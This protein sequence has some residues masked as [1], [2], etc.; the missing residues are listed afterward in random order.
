MGH[1]EKIDAQDGKVICSRAKNNKARNR[2]EVNFEM[3]LLIPS[4]LFK[5]IRERKGTNNKIYHR[6]DSI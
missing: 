2:F 6:K 5:R 1:V 4:L 3:S